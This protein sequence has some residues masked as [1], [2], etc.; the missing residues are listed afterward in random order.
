MPMLHHIL[1]TDSIDSPPPAKEQASAM[2]Y[3]VLTIRVR[4]NILGHM[5]AQECLLGIAVCNLQRQ[6]DTCPTA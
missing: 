5:Q 2:M 4:R 3:D 6:D 1:Q